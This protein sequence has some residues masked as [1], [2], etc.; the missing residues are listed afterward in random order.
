MGYALPNAEKLYAEILSLPI[1]PFVTEDDIAY[2][3]SNIQSF[4]R[5]V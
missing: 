1:H 4:F 2:I 5:N 3:I